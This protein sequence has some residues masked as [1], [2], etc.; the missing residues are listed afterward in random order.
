MEIKGTNEKALEAIEMA[1]KYKTMMFEYLFLALCSAGL[2]LRVYNSFYIM[3]IFIIS[4]GAAMFMYYNFVNLQDRMYEQEDCYIKLSDTYLEFRQ[5]INGE[6]QI[7][8]IF[9][10]DIKRVMKV[11]NGFQIWIDKNA[12]NSRYMIDDDI[13]EDIET[14]CIDYY[15]FDS[16]EYI[17]LYLEFLKKLPEETEKE[18]DVAEWKEHSVFTDNLKL[19]VPSFLYAIAIILI[20]I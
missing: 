16:N 14:M 7:G 15:S 18:L 5:L 13:I 10:N 1:K 2:F 3:V 6:Y 9:I 12:E 11:E 8:K 4:I 17:K 20:F 19:L